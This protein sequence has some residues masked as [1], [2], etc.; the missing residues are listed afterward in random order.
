MTDRREPAGAPWPAVAPEVVAEVVSA[1]S[2]RLRKRLDGAAAK[3][4]D[5]PVV[6]AGEEWRVRIDEE[7]ELVLHAPGGVVRTAGDVRCG[8]LLAPG[9]LHRAA[10]VT[11]APLAEDT[12]PEP[13]PEPQAAPETVPGTAPEAEAVAVQPLTEAE[14]AAVHRLRL[15]A[16]QTLAAGI[17]GAGSVLQA[18][19]L[20]TAHQAR[21]LGLHR[22]AALA[23]TVVTRL[24]AARSGAPGHRLA[25]LVAAHR[26]L[27][28]AVT[29][30]PA[31][32]DALRGTARQS[33]REAGS[34]RLYG[35][36]A[37]PVVTATHAGVTVWTVDADGALATVSDVLPHA[38]PA[39]AAQLARAAAG[40]PVRLGDASLAHREL[41]RGGL[42]VQGATRTVSGRLGAGAQVRAAGASGA[43]WYR[44]PVARLWA[45]P[46]GA[47]VERALRAGRTPAELR[48]AGDELLF[49]DV[50]VLGPGAVPGEAAP[51]LLAD[52]A[53]RTV[54]LLPALEHPRLAYGANLALLAGVPGLRLRVVGRLERA[55]HP[56]LR[57]LA[58]APGPESSL[59]LRP[60]YRERISLGL[61]ELQQA[62]LPP[63]GGPVPA[64]AG[65]P[66]QPPL[67]LLAR[68]LEQAVT[69]G[70]DGLAARLAAGATEGPRLRAAGLATAEHLL[71]ALRAAAA[72]QE[73][74]V[75][76]RLRTD[77]RL[78]YA[79]AWSTVAGYAEELATALCA[80]AWHREEDG[81]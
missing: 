72:D 80:A 62:D 40:R 65:L 13:P 31:D 58:A 36:F 23:A 50:T 5:R 61:E 24:R 2:E 33:Y 43:D 48:P 68:P 32:P 79:T 71:T 45:E 63:A 52:C 69:T 38:D 17:G 39:Q 77:D 27:L 49:L 42:V 20:R 25:D 56:R 12:A 54:A 16:A 29:V 59:A 19:L 3:L 34:L 53:G 67:H 7:A 14:R 1:L 6:R 41:A 26:E 75:F 47:Q 10:A 57:L 55:A 66:P 44:E 9:C 46:V 60:E 78:A 37:E 22:P 76:G 64:S 35:L 30:G 8:C 73:R 18:E 15:T 28:D 4:A 70:R 21:L 51:R 74:D 11:F 81:T